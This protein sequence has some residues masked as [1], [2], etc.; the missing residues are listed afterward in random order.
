MAQRTRLILLGLIMERRSAWWTNIRGQCMAA[1]AQ[2]VDLILFKHPLIRGTVRRMADRA[3]L[4]LRFMLIDKRSLLFA[5]TLVANLVAGSIRAQLPGAERA[6]WTMAIIAMDQT[7]VQ[8][9]VERPR[10]LCTHILVAS[11]TELRRFRLHQILTLLGVMRRVAINASDAVGQ[12]HRA[13]IVAMLFG[14]LMAAQAARAGLLWRGVFKREDFR[15]VAAA[16]YVLFPRPMASFAS[17]P[18][19]A[20]VR[21]EL[22]IHGGGDVSGGGE[23]RIDLFVAGLAGIGTDVE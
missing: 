7:F 19:H 9:M 18:F 16:I 23:I 13:V 3:A 4:D 14:V 5:V 11:V 17:V 21:V 12:V 6:M 15:F 20:F 2:Q 8:A 10:E 22:A 1:E